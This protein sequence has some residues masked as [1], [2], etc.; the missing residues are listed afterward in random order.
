M[1]NVKNIDGT[2]PSADM[3]VVNHLFISSLLSASNIG[4]ADLTESYTFSP[5][6][7]LQQHLQKKKTV[8]KVLSHDYI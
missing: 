3:I 5:I 7:C 2:H 4:S 6:V 8:Q 1:S